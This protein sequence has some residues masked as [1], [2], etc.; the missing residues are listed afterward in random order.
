MRDECRTLGEDSKIEQRNL[1]P[2]ADDRRIEKENENIY[3]IFELKVNE[4]NFRLCEMTAKLKQ[5]IEELRKRI[6]EAIEFH[7]WRKTKG[8]V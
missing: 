8:G 7:S 3:L 6:M 5:K 2:Q 4:Q 1:R